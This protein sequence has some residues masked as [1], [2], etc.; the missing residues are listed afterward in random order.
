[1][2]ANLSNNEYSGVLCCNFTR[3]KKTRLGVGF[4]AM[5]LSPTK[6]IK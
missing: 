6:Q 2:F 1:M 5:L 4:D 3:Y